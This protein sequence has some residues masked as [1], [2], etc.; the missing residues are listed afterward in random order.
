[1]DASVPVASL[2]GPSG[3]KWDSLLEE[4]H[5]HR[6]TPYYRA[7]EACESPIERIML[8]AL[9]NTS[10]HWGNHGREWAGELPV[11]GMGFPGVADEDECHSIG[12]GGLHLALQVPVRAG[13]VAYRVDIVMHSNTHC[14][15]DNTGW[16]RGRDVYVAIECDGHDF[17]ERTKE[18]AER[19]KKRDRDIQSL[20]WN[21]ARF[22]G[23]EIVRDPK[24]TAD[25]AWAL[26]SSLVGANR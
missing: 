24:G 18:Q 20:G 16:R 10:I 5:A 23:S 12:L 11:G 9:I 22:T 17:H 4:F 6:V 1:M 19:D 2:P 3:A 8:L 21:V 14:P 15:G 25:K 13:G 26:A 7:I